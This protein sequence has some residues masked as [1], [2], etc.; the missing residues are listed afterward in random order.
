MEAAD[1]RVV[2]DGIGVGAATG[3]YGLSFGAIAVAS[4]LSVLQT[5]V[6]SLVMFSGASQFAIVGVIGGGGSAFAG[7][8]SAV[9]LGARN[10]FYGMRLSPLLDLRGAR[11]VAAAQLVI[12]EST[13]M[14]LA[15]EEEGRGRLA[16]FAAGAS[17]F[18]LW[19][20]GTL[21]GA[22]AAGHLADPKALGLDAAVPAAFLALLAPRLVGREPWVVAVLG[23]AVAIALAPFVPVG[24][25]V[26]AAAAVAVLVG[27]RARRTA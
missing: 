6:L 15:H 14:A 4:H 20:L 22:L 1:R 3:A 5:C 16:F 18:V 11:K 8:A 2:R 21:V 24:L 26:L 12:D 10:A 7:A 17:I 25:P 9:L 19:N 13:A 27:A 23:A